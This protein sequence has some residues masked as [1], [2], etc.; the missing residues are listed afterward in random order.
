METSLSIANSPRPKFLS[1]EEML[2]W[3][4]PESFALDKRSAVGFREKF[5]WKPLNL[6]QAFKACK[7]NLALECEPA[8]A[9]AEKPNKL[10]GSRKSDPL[11]SSTNSKGFELCDFKKS[12]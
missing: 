3:F 12:T 1:K 11:N 9:T 5:L 10:K 2:N 8:L 7:C 6:F 4:L